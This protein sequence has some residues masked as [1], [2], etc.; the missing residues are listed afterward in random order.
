MLLIQI[1]SEFPQILGIKES[2]IKYVFEP[3]AEKVSRGGQ[4]LA[5]WAQW[6]WACSLPR[7]MFGRHVLQPAFALVAVHAAVLV[8]LTRNLQPSSG[9]LLTCLSCMLLCLSVEGR[10]ARDSEGDART[11][12]KACMMHTPD[13]IGHGRQACVHGC[14]VAT[15]QREESVPLHDI[16]SPDSF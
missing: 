12:N 6:S 4:K 8:C 5:S 3:S 7:L 9:W 15:A 13:W 16:L 10:A 2:L 11:V 14:S 1:E